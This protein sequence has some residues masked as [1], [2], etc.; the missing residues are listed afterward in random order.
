MKKSTFAQNRPSRALKLFF[1][2]NG[3]YILCDNFIG[4]QWK[5]FEDASI[6]HF[7]ATAIK[8][9]IVGG[10]QLKSYFLLKIG[11]LEPPN[12]YC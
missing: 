9:R 12:L 10:K 8:T 2:S 3:T 1:N 7:C 11:Y 5:H 4:V 6:S